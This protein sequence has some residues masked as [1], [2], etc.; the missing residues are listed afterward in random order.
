LILDWS[1]VKNRR[2]LL[3]LAFAAHC[4]LSSSFPWI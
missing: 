2:N 3:A 4:A 1:K